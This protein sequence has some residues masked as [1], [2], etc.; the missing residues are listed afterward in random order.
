M[1]KKTLLSAAIASTFA[2]SGCLDDTPSTGENA[3]AVTNPD[4]STAVYPIFSP[5]ESKLPIP[6]DLIFDADAADGSFKVGDSSPP[7]TTAING[8]SGASTVAPIDIAMSAAIDPTSLVGQEDPVNQNVFLLELDYATGEPVR[9]LSI[10][11]PPTVI[12]GNQKAYA[13]EHKTLDG[14]SY[15]RI[16]PK[17]PLSPLKRYVVVITTGVTDA[18]GNAI[19]QSPGAAGY[20]A[21]S[22]PSTVLAG[23]LAALT[24]VKSLISFWESIALLAIPTLGGDDDKIAMTYSFTT[25]GDEKVLGYISEPN[26]W[27]ADQ[28]SS[29][30]KLSTAE[31]TI[32]ALGDA[33]NYTAISDQISTVFSAIPNIPINEDGLLLGQ[34]LAPYHGAAFGAVGCSG[35]TPPTE[36]GQDYLDC[37]GKV[38]AG[39]PLANGGFAEYM[40][41]FSST[42]T[43]DNA[44]TV[45]L[46]A[47]APAALNIPAT[48]FSLTPGIMTVPYYSGT[49]TAT[50]GAALK[51]SN[52][53]A[54]NTL[55]EA[56]NG[57][58]A[59]LGLSLPQGTKDADGNYVSNVV[60]YVFPFPK[61]Q[62]G[63][64]STTADYTDATTIA[65]TVED[66]TIPI[67][68]I[69][70]N[71]GT[72]MKAMM[73]AHGLTGNRTNALGFGSAFVAGMKGQGQ[74][75]ALFAI[76]APLHGLDDN[77]DPSFAFN[78]PYERHFG[79]QDAGPGLPPTDIDL[80][81]GEGS[82]SMF[83]NL[84]NLLT[85]RDSIRQ[86]V[87]DLKTLRQN[88]HSASITGITLSTNTVAGVGTFADDVYYSGHSLGTI[89]GQTF[90][91]V[92]TQTATPA[93]NLKSASF[94]TPGGGITRFIENSPT[95]APTVATGLAA[96]GVTVDTSGYQTYLNVLQH[97]LDAADPINF[98]DGFGST[99]V[100][101]VEALG[102]Q[103]I[104]NSM[105][106]E[107]ETLKTTLGNG[108]VLDGS[109]SYLSGSEPLAV[110]TS[111]TTL[112][113]AQALTP[114][115][116][117]VVR[118]RFS[119]D[120]INHGTPSTADPAQ[121]FAEIVSQT[122][123]LVVSNGNAMLIADDTIL[124][125]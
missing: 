40:P 119:E 59:A 57:T 123:S 101:Y 54:N 6:N 114:L 110:L 106:T 53:V 41:S 87:L 24:P 22:D 69:Y 77:T 62:D 74:D 61:K 93:D 52:W 79:Y 56:I 45:D 121:A 125:P 25:S 37:V 64:P 5:A 14:T 3:G 30:I 10:S 100:H 32:D 21:L 8:L 34:A 38:L 97:A 44:S 11:E 16:N 115:P 91:S 49:P 103:V 124:E 20:E 47:V 112:S 81:T 55:A 73:W 89:G 66:V 39:L 33:A 18:N 68:S 92:A 88:L 23:A 70:A 99:S 86:H 29:F 2:L 46:S 72:G 63:D 98:V 28:L 13:I 76:D 113:A 51:Y 90:V 17:T 31:S 26:T 117:S 83:I 84:E 96:N 48:V 122:V 94:F 116:S 1:L 85:S 42:I 82:G 71:G 58:F 60:N 95:F 109:V 104:P 50:S 108:V 111:A 36:T 67:L 7:V 4:T 12:P 27:F 35:T 15:I 102:D 65:A 75:V 105:D 107:A 43:M 19:T 118:T 9:G 120:A 78:T 80:S